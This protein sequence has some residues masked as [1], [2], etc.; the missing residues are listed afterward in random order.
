MIRV[1]CLFQ[2]KQGLPFIHLLCVC[3]HT[4][5]SQVR[6]CVCLGVQEREIRNQ[7]H[8]LGQASSALLVRPEDTC[9]EGCE[10]WAPPDERRNQEH[11]VTWRAI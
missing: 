9:S 7:L 8:I 10:G 5:V 4:C 6:V 11:L 2:E 1:L 3:V